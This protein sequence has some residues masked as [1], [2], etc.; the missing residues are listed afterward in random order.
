MPLRPLSQSSFFN[1]EFVSPGCL[2]RGTVPWFLARHRSALFPGWLMAGWRGEG[3]GRNAWPPVVLMTLVLL[4]WS[5]EG[6]SRLASVEEART[7]MAWRAAMGIA[8]DGA[9]PS[10]RTLRDFEKWLRA[11]HPAGPPRYMLMHEHIVRECMGRLKI[12]AAATWAT[13]STP[14]WCYGAVLDTVRQLGD[15]LRMLGRRWARATGQSLRDVAAEWK[16]G[17]LLK[18]KSTKG[19][20]PIDWRDAEARDKVVSVL[21]DAV[22]DVVGRVRS[23]MIAVHGSKRN[24]LLSLCRR[25]LKVVTEDLES[26]DKHRLV[27]AKRVARDRLVSLTD[28][29]ARHGRKS[30]SKCFNGYKLH[31]LGDVVSGL[32]A[33]VTVTQGNRHDGSVAHRLIERAKSLVND[34]DCVLGDTAY[35]AMSLRA[36]VQ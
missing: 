35:G 16:L 18:A 7:N 25:L 23:N 17:R 24:A 33:S 13:D 9:V 31:V 15:G 11:R 32:I 10:E 5:G 34:I 1:P 12:G 4:R 14:M 20:L 8:L 27:V 36:T 22:V 26:D 29:Q 2:R 28:P 21:A 6:M 19:A 30:K 3:R